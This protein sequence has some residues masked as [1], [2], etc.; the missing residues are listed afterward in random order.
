MRLTNDLKALISK[1]AWNKYPNECCGLIINDA[2]HPCKNIATNPQA[3]FEICPSDYVAAAELGKIQAIVHS[4]PDGTGKL[5]EIDHQQMSLHG[6][7]WVICGLGSI[8]GLQYTD[9]QHHACPVPL[10]GR[11]YCHGVQ[12]CYSIVQDY[13]KQELAISLPDFER[14]DNWWEDAKSPPL[15][16]QNIA[17]AGF[18][19]VTDLKPHDLILCCVGRTH[20]I[21]HALIYLGNYQLKSDSTPAAVQSA[22]ILHHPYGEL[23]RREIYDASWQKR[24]KM[25]LRHKNYENH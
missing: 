10:I 17:N 8:N 1:H 5:S 13:Y 25:I 22:V 14:A 2:Y 12:D 19:E 6:F 3:N 24:T 15:Y 23:S 9:V 18:Y 11:I 4:H 20:H 7:D 21:N 16:T